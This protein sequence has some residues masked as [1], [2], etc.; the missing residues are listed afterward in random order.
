[1]VILSS[2]QTSLRAAGILLLFLIVIGSVIL[3]YN[4]ELAA[5]NAKV[6][7][8]QASVGELESQLSSAQP[9]G[10]V[11]VV[12]L[13]PVAIYAS[14]NDSVVTV[15]GSRSVTVLTIFGPQTS[16]ESVLGSGFVIENSNSYYVVTNFHVVDSMVNTTVTFWNGNAYAATVVGSDPYSDIAVLTTRAP[17]SDLHSLNFAASSSLRVG[18][19]VLAIGNPFGLSGSVTFGI[20]SQV[21]R[22][23]QY[24]STT[25]TFTIADAIQFSA[26]INPG[27]S[28]G[29]LLN[30]NGVVL[31]ITSAAVT[32]SQGV[33]FA[34][35][36]DTILRELP[37]LISTGKYNMHPY[38]G[39]QGDDMNYE[40]AQAIGTNYTYG[41]L[42]EKT[43]PGGPV[44]KAGLRGGPNLITVGTQNYLIGGD[45]IVSINGT[46][47]VNYD[48]LATYIERHAIPGQ[49]IE[50]GIVRSDKLM[51]VQVVVGAQPS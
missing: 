6:S 24:Q 28:G 14:S 35:P 23:I 2:K 47:I 34:I 10:N 36:S 45:I 49:T 38:L 40:L 16:V 44:D 20:I 25:G 19:P 1:L 13:N 37:F 46:R 48:S 21:G 42:I 33:G 4:S 11:S 51:M 3:Y 31:G 32:G 50:L 39:F 30:A 9:Q 29:P 41:V 8:L 7:S 5:A 43:V 17:E 26:P 18:Q 12:G 27:N 15:Q 22:T